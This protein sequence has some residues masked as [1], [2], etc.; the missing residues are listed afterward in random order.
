MGTLRP[1]GTV[2]GPRLSGDGRSGAAGRLE[3]DLERE[4]PRVAYLYLA[5]MDSILHQ[6]GTAGVEVEAK[7]RDYEE[8]LRSVLA[9]ARRQGQNDVEVLFRRERAWQS[10]WLAGTLLGSEV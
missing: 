2:R 6:V 3:R 5:S 4:Q 7:I 8:N 10:Q 1:E 9:V